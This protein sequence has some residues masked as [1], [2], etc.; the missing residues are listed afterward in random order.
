MSGLDKIPVVF[1][2]ILLLISQLLKV[3]V[4]IWTRLTLE[5]G[6]LRNRS[7]GVANYQ[8]I[9]LSP[10]ISLIASKFQ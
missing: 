2:P 10:Q 1:Y 8:P 3:F 4:H 6:Q 9:R 7:Q 5:T